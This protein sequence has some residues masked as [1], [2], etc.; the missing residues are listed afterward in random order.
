MMIITEKTKRRFRNV[1]ITL[2]V[3]CI[4]PLCEKGRMLNGAHT[5]NHFT[6]KEMVCV[7]DLGNDIYSAHGLETGF[8]YELLGRL[9][10]DNHCDIRIVAAGKNDNY[11]DS[12]RQGKVDIVITH[13]KDSLTSKESDMFKT[14][15]DCSVWAFNINEEESVMQLNRW[16]SHITTSDDFQ[17]MKDRY[18]KTYNPHKRAENGIRT[19]TISPYDSLIRK[20]ADELGWD[21][22]MLASVIYQES[23]FAI[24]S[25]SH[26]GACGLMQVMPSTAEYY[27][28]DNLLDPEQNIIAGTRHLKRLQNMFR[29]SGL[30]GEEL[31]KFTLAAYNAGEGRVI[32]CRNLAAAKDFDNTRWDEVVKVIPMMREDSILD[33]PSVK[34][35]KFQG[36]ETID[37]VGSV[38][39]HY[40]A[41]CEICQSV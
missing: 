29:K 34:L 38:L 32:D 24:G 14:V 23:K 39:S 13:D 4:T 18:F 1:V 31:V 6:G 37:Y 11:I 10:K 2:A 26:R 19:S 20:Y 21:W 22:R 30:S 3:I 36:H 7:I 15:S 9:A 17:T 27:G 16:I 33:E 41:F 35:G 25:R 8:N 40:E 12:L 28:I 5:V